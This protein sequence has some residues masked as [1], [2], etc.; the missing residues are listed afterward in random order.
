MAKAL[1]VDDVKLFLE[2]EKTLLMNRGMEIF[3]ATSGKEAIEI[4]RREKVDLI[5]LD[6]N[7]PDLTGADVCRVIRTDDTLKN[8]SIIM[9]T[10]RGSDEDAASCLA[11]GA[12]DV[13]AK[14]INRTELLKKVFKYTN[15]SLRSD[16]RLLVRLQAEGLT[17]RSEVFAG[18]T[19]NI[20]STGFLLETAQKFSIGDTATFNI[21][22][23]GFSAKIPFKGEVAREATNFDSEKSYGGVK[24]NFYGIIFTEVSTELKNYID[25]F[26]KSQSE[27]EI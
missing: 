18:M 20:S 8:V 24:T 15:I 27:A 12:N 16:T 25:Y 7:L 5:L 26:V 23:P 17:E 21:S 6:F 19:R 22:F 1:L 3:T 2:L 9:V 11:A 4:H 13:I 10:T 14:P